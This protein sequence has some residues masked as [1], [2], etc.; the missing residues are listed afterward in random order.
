V[1]RRQ[2]IA[3]LGFATLTSL[4]GQGQQRERPR[5]IG[6]LMGFSQDDAASKV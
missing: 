1:K 2:F 4:P 6:V 3:G 5:R